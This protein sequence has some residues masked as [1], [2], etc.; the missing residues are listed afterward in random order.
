MTSSTTAAI[1][2]GIIYIDSRV[3]SRELAPILHE[4]HGLQTSLCVLN[5]G[6]V[7]FAC[8]HSKPSPFCAGDHGCRIAVERKTI[9]D[10]VGSLLK[11]RLDGRQIPLMCRDYTMAWIVREGVWRIAKDGALEIPF[12][13]RNGTDRWR[14]VSLTYQQLEGWLTRYEVRSGGKIHVRDTAT[15]KQTAAFIAAK[16]RWWHKEW[17]KHSEGGVDKVPVAEKVLMFQLN[18][19]ERVIASFDR[20]GMKRMKTISAYFDS[21]YGFLLASPKELQVAGL[22]KKDSY[23]VWKAV[24]EHVRRRR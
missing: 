19:Y 20:I 12:G 17:G 3:G 8:G 6:D 1:K 5:S 9:T 14:A 13:W 11:N 24:R 21:I 4:H 15:M 7:A 22:G 10:L 16:F 23:A 2:P 18:Q